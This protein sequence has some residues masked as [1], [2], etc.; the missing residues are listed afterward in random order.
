MAA[1]ARVIVNLMDLADLFHDGPLAVFE[2]LSQQGLILEEMICDKCMPIEAL[3]HDAPDVGEL[4]EMNLVF[5]NGELRWRC[6]KH[7]ERTIRHHSEF[8]TWEHETT[9]DGR[10][11]SNR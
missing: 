6:S 8:F 11:N 7:H 10:N 5:R 1:R 4:H 3:V 9:A 2:F